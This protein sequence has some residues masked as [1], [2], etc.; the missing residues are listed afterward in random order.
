MNIILTCAGRRNYIVKYFQEALNHQ[1]MVFACDVSPE[2]AALQEADKSFVLPPVNHED[3]LD[4]LLYICEQNHIRLL[5]SL[6]DLELPL[7]SKQRDRFA[8]IG[9][10]LAVSSTFVIDTCFDKWTSFQ[11]LTNHN[12]PTAKTYLSLNQAR[13][14]IASSEIEYPVVVKP[15]WGSASIGIQYP[16]DDEELELAYRYVNKLITKTFLSN[17]SASEPD[18]SVIIQERI[19][20][21]EYGLD[22]VNNFQGLYQTTF[23]KRKLKMRAGETDRATTIF[24]PKLEKLGEN[25]SQKLGHI[26]NLDC[27]VMMNDSDFFI[28]EMNP[29]FGGGYPFSHH[30]GAN[31]PAALIAWS[32]GEKINQKWLQVKNNITSSK[33]DRLVKVNFQ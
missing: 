8:E 28:L 32:K 6:N 4:K 9:T 1:G 15:R 12:I 31:I 29:R 16:E 10:I 27:D 24:S 7:L 5:V 19:T 26:A 23:V 17:I 25:I 2:A 13:Q 3:Y 30:A 22:I 18:K 33:C 20:G 14:A 11:F 21:Q